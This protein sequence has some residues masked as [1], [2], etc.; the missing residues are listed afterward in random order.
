MNERRP[1]LM[2]VTDPDR[3]LLACMRREYGLGWY[4]LAW[5]GALTLPTLLIVAGIVILAGS[6]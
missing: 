3:T 2:E 4:A 6:S 1:Y 5:V